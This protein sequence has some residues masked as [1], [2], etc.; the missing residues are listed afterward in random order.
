MKESLIERAKVIAA[1]PPKDYTGAAMTAKYISMK[2]VDR[3]SILINVGAWAGGTA[4]V[5]LAQA[6]DVSAT[7]AKALS[8]TKQWNDVVAD[9][10]LVETAV[11]ANTFN[12]DST[13]AN[14]QI[15]IEVD[16]ADLDVNNDFDCLTLAIASPGAN[17]DF[18]SVEYVCLGLRYQEDTPPTVLVD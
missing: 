3:V 2:N 8:F 14:K 15:V 9:G 4:A 10:T 16:A 7:G 5:T 18:Y 11:A 1:A 6:T 17:S 12:I 13:Y